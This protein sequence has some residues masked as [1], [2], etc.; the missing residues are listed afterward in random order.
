MATAIP[1]LT[2]SHR[3]S[4]QPGTSAPGTRM[5][6]ALSPCPALDR[7]MLRL[8]VLC[9]ILMAANMFYDLLSGLWIR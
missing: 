5:Q 1:Q 2:T 6:A 4:V 7:L 8:F 9:F 3:E